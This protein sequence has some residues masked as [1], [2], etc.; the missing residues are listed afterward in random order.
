MT[1][2]LIEV[3]HDDRRDACERAIK[4]FLETG[5][6][7]MTH[8]D[9][10]CRDGEHKAWIVVELESKD[11]AR[12]ILPPLFR[13]EAKIV[14]LNKFTMADLERIKEEHQS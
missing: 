4:V 1:R 12:A 6:H 13:D 14:A 10:G 8:A 2:Y 3:P 11:E 9:W 5:S 7:Y